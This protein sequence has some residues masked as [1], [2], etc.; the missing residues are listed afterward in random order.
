MAACCRW[1]SE[2]K[3]VCL[4]SS[5][6]CSIL[7]DSRRP[8][9]PRAILR[10][11]TCLR[12]GMCISWKWC[13]NACCF[14]KLDV[15]LVSSHAYWEIVQGKQVAIVFEIWVAVE[16]SGEQEASMREQSLIGLEDNWRTEATS[17]MNGGQKC[18]VS[19]DPFLLE[20]P[21]HGSKCLSKE[22]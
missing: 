5:C 15:L 9:I 10:L 20:Y 8:L 13:S 14:S 16:R 19:R 3:V 11:M 18:G 21:L 12:D 4:C 22:G 7:T 17:A 1:Q 6:G 2:V